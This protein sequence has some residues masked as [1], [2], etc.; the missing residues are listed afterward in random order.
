MIKHLNL[1]AL[2]KAY[3]W[4]S[5][6]SYTYEL[7]YYLLIVLVIFII[8]FTVKNVQTLIIF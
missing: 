6:N 3:T 2:A 7:Y 1:N 4:N 8:L 5:F